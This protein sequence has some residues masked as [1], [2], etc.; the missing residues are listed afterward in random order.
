MAWTTPRTWS[1]GEVVTAT[2]LNAQIKGNM[3]LTAPAVMTTAGDIIYASG[4]NTP[5]R[6]AKDTN[7]TR[8]LANTG[9]SNV[10]AWA[11]VNVTNGVTGT[12]PVGNGGT[13]ATTLTDGGVLIGNGTG[14]M[15]AMAVLA[16][17][18]LIVGDGTTDPVAESG[19]TL[20]T[21]IGVGTGDAV[22]FGGLTLGSDG[23]GVD[24]IFYSGTS[25]DNMTW[26]ASDKV[27]NITGTDAETAL[28]VLDG[29]V[30]IV[31]KL[32]FYDRGGEY[33]S[34]NGSLMTLTGDVT[35]S[36]DLT[37][38]GTTTTINSTVTT[39][40]DPL[41]IYAVGTSGS[42]SNDAG[43]VIERGDDTNV[44]WIW[45]ESADEFVAVTTNEDG[46]TAGNVTIAAYAGIH[47][48]GA[49]VDGVLNV[50]GSIDF[51]GTTAAL[52]GSGAITLTS[53]SSSANGIHLHANGGTSETIKI[54]SD[55]GTSVTEGAASVSLLSDA[56]GVEL[57]STANL[58]NAINITNDG[59]TTGTITI[60]NDQGTAVN[61]GVASIQLLSDV[62]GVGIKSGLNAAGALRLTADGGTSETII[63]HADQGT[64]ADSINIMS[65]DGGITLAVA[66]GKSILLHGA[67]V[68]NDEVTITYNATDT[69]VDCTKGNKFDLTFG[70]GNITDLYLHPP[71]GPANIMLRLVQ[72]G[73]GSRVVTNWYK[74]GGSVGS[75]SGTTKVHFAG[76]EKPTLTTT[77]NAVDVFAFYYDGSNFH[78]TTSLDSK[79]YS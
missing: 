4:A 74:N 38:S 52:D 23:S 75:P 26:D 51:D 2:L 14:A 13:G 55:Q 17:G 78:G 30:R 68:F 72:D 40:A 53:T 50:D 5:V 45:D 1:T 6:L 56:G 44:A 22:T 57:R 63:L 37:V 48:N 73:T 79:A 46:T 29:D 77:G 66:D 49:E 32:Y 8:Y 19:A 35:V 41:V 39:V 67:T 15:V 71:D 62:G 36:G 25:G 12:L 28:D 20:R 61:E 60:F 9:S 70:A 69:V 43:F 27:L 65:D 64:G 76:G 10:P 54:H 7:A 34:S 24:A 16:D 3:D 47:V 33:I 18:E 21:S 59:G 11:Q 42:A 58:A 31:D